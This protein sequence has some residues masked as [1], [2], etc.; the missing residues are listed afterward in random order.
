MPENE[1]K[2]DLERERLHKAIECYLSAI[3]SIANCIAD[4]CPDI[5]VPFR[6]QW[7]RIPQRIG[8]DSTLESLEK[9]KRSFKGSIENLHQL[10]KDYFGAGLPALREIGETG[11]RT[12]E[13]VLERNASFAAMMATLA[14]SLAA[15][16]DLDAPPELRDQ[17]EQH[18]AGLRSAARTVEAEIIPP[19]AQLQKVVQTCGDL[20]RRIHENC[21][22]DSETGVL[23]AQGFLGELSQ[24]VRKGPACV[25]TMDISATDAQGKPLA[26]AGFRHLSSNLADRITE[27]FR[28]FDSIG[29]LSEARFAVLFGGTAEQARVRQQSMARSISGQ[30]AG[31]DGKIKVK[32]EVKVREI[33][34]VESAKSLVD[35]VPATAVVVA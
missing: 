4:V 2:P 11:G 15:T 32:A 34:N 27:Q 24:A 22:V 21:M 18:A 33:E 29:R 28:A 20:M 1:T 5:G 16:A 31:T 26:A 12:V 9:S 19:L 6:N 10:S 3:V 17:L 7:R 30:Y 25:V 13:L 14:D 35:G 23:S 8:F